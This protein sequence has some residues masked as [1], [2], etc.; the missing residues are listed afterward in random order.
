MDPILFQI[1]PLTVRYYGLLMALAFLAGYFIFRRISK[2]EM[3]GNE[4]DVYFIYMIIGL[5][6]GARLGQVIFYDPLFYLKYP[7]EILAIWHGGLASHGAFIGGIIATIIFCRR[8]KKRFY[9]IADLIVVPVALGAAFVR[10]GNFINGE[11]VGRVANAHLPW[12]MKF[13]G[14]E[15]LRH[16]VQIYEAIMNVGVF[17]ILLLL[18]KVKRLPEG[19]VSWSFVL[20][21]SFLRFFLEFFKEYEGIVGPWSFLTMG[22][23]LCAAFFIVS[24]IMMWVKYRHFLGKIYKSGFH[25]K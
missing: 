12:A 21:Y 15:G 3:S 18:R 8:H 7:L 14:Y 20:V 10:I 17:C 19:L 5:T 9:R 6:A 13:D 2:K 24:A 11:I 23:Y 22:Q 4:T 25:N 16:P 1:G